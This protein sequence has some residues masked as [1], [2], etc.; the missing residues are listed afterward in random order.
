MELYAKRVATAG[1]VIKQ[2]GLGDQRAK[3]ALVLDISGSMESEYRRGRVQTIVERLLALGARFDDNQAIDTFAFGVKCYDLGELPESNFD[4]WVK[5]VIL[6]KYSLEPG[7]NYAG[8][9]KMIMQH[10]YPNTVKLVKGGFFGGS[11]ETLPTSPVKSTEDPAYVMF[12]TDGNN[13][14]KGA[15]DLAITA[16]A[17]LGIF[18]QFI[19]IGGSS[20]GY[21][22]KLD[23][24]EG[25]LVDNAN[26]F[27]ARNID[28]L[29]D[30]ELYGL[31]LGEFPDW[32][33][34][35]KQLG[36]Y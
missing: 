3:V 19:G 18:W 36:L 17:N 4:G 1:E 14:D 8:V 6:K 24:M 15:T 9:M 31:M 22:E 27:Q 35:A 20:F 23:E 16:A 33:K 11:K 29:S 21:L 2:K 7:T 32:L 12:I 34:K 5:R 10:Y 26:F 13:D 28:Q 30:E 25:R